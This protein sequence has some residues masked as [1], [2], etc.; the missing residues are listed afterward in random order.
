M[1]VFSGVQRNYH[2]VIITLITV[3]GQILIIYVG[4]TSFGVVRLNGVQWATS[5]VLGLLSLPFA[6]LIRLL[7]NT[8][9][10]RFI[11]RF[12]LR[13][14]RVRPPIPDIERDVSTRES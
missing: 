4:G 5:I 11:P 1:N 10:E 3:G 9:I 7:P 6:V 14:R 8:F 12:T 2:F 13:R